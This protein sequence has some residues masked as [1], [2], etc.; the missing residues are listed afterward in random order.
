MPRVTVWNEYRHEKT[1]PAVAAIY[2]DGIHTT[3]ASA[4][5][6]HGI[7]ASTATMDEPEHGLSPDVLGS[8]DVLIWWGHLAHDEVG[9]AVVD[10]VQ[11]RVLDGMGL[12]VLHSGHGSKIFRRLMGTSCNLK[13]RESTD[14][15]VLWNVA[16]GHPITEGVE[17]NLI[18]DQEEMYG[19]FFDIPTPETLVFISWFTGGEV[20]RSGAVYQRGAGRIFYFRPGHET[21]PTYHNKEI[22]RVIANAARWASRN[23]DVTQKFGNPAPLMPPGS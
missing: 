9:D 15:E 10:R 12:I 8:T 3:I 4:L 19:E 16:P 18:L 23:H 14:S 13:W 21:Y 5:G 2:P 7:E 11:Q 22:Q 1:D 17:E 20:F 6:E